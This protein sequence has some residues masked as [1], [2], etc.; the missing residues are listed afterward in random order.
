MH[1]IVPIVKDFFDGMRYTDLFSNLLSARIVMIYGEID[2][3]VAHMTI[4]KLLY[5]D[6]ESKKPL[7]LYINSPGGSAIDGLAIYDAMQHIGSEIITVCMGEASSAASLLFAAGDKRLLCPH[8]RILVH[9]PMGGRNGQASD[10]RIYVEEI[11][12]LKKQVIDIYKK[13][14]KLD[15]ETLVALMDRDSIIR[16][17][18]AI[19]M[20]FAD[21]IVSPTK[22]THSGNDSVAEGTV[23]RKK[24]NE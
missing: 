4:A 13:H 10:L 14:T 7:Y 5:L 15:E 16:G 11:E 8:A 22:K 1:N 24:K 23:K 3:S 12:M 20:G 2:N 18:K 21:Q 9:Q 6:A 17:Q 19:D